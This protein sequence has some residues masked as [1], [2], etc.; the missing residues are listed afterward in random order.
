M[1]TNTGV[2]GGVASFL[3][4][5]L[6]VVY[7]VTTVIGLATLPSPDDPI[8]DPYFTIMEATIIVLMPPILVTFG[9]LYEKA[10]S[11]DSHVLFNNNNNNHRANTRLW[12]LASLSMMVIA[13]SITSSVHAA[14]L[15]ANRTIADSA[16][17]SS[18]LYDALFSF[19]WPSVVYALDILAW[20]W[21]F[22]LGLVFQAVAFRPMIRRRR[23]EQDRESDDGGTVSVPFCS[24]STRTRA[25]LFWLLLLSGLLSLLGLIAIPLN[26]IQVRIIGIV[27]YAVITI[28]TFC[29]MGVFLKL[30][31]PK[32]EATSEEGA[33]AAG[34]KTLNDSLPASS[35]LLVKGEPD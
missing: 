5:V 32:E 20:D 19:R 35:L 9:A 24:H 14:V 10:S 28:P 18:E 4:A 27:G 13:T 34:D 2:L 7:L 26:N 15:V 16:G 33:P 22:G 11:W 3:T 30:E 21:F 25:A 12:S 29:T 1:R 8:Q 31:D 6:L 17:M 23:Q